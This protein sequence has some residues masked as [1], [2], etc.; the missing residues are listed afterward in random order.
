MPTWRRL[1]E[2]LDGLDIGFCL[3]DD[4]DRTATW[5]RSFL[6]LFPEHEGRVH[7]GEPYGEN[8]RRFYTKRLSA[9]DLP[10]I[11]RH[12]SDGIAR[13]RAQSRPFVFYHD[14]QWLRVASLPMPEGGR[15]RIWTRIADPSA[16]GT[17]PPRHG[18]HTAPPTHRLEALA[19]AVMVLDASGNVTEAN[20]A[21]LALYGVADP[22]AILGKSYEAVL[23]AAWTMTPAS[24]EERSALDRALARLAED[25]RFAGAP[26][27]VP[28]PGGRWL[29]V[30]EQHGTDGILYS[31]HIDIT[32]MKLQQAVISEARD[33]AHRANLTK[34][35]FLAMMSHE[36]RTPMHGIIGMT[37][38]LL[39]SRLDSGQRAQ[40]EAIQ[41]SAT[42]L[43]TIL[44]DI[45]DVSRLEMGKV[46]LASV[47]FSVA[48]LVAD[49]GRILRP[50]AEARGLRLDVSAAAMLQQPVLG[51][52]ARVRQVLLNL[53][54][55]AVKFT[56]T[57]SITIRADIGGGEMGPQL[58]LEVSDT[59]IGFEES[60]L[61]QLFGAFEQGGPDIARRFGGTGLG[62]SISR[63]LVTMMG[64]RIAATSSPGKGSCF[65]VDLPLVMS[66]SE[67]PPPT[68]AP[69][70]S[71][72]SLPIAG[73]RILVVE[74]NPTNQVLA[75]AIL[76]RQ[77]HEV[78]LARDGAAAIAAAASYRPDLVLMDVQ[79]PDMDGFSAAAILRETVPDGA[80]LPIV[81]VTANAMAGDRERCLA[82]GM[83]DYLPKPFKRSDLIAMV[84]RW[85]GGST[86]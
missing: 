48:E 51:D 39:D 42:A 15:I 78:V 20:R 62:L 12:I 53:A 27:E 85:R 6:R 68:A 9:A 60:R 74:D 1:G 59:G 26:F 86:G 40:A 61:E 83:N 72:I 19:D 71:A 57:G 47:P 38:L 37:E 3:F 33:A 41:R 22:S 75:E 10:D 8:L 77:G 28:L 45:L 64:G 17:L 31:T 52:P 73:A 14:G 69:A 50:A 65:R 66:S 43:L 5:N 82:R 54:S 58:L 80:S 84:D 55:N 25:R 13:H 7:V 56:L 21:F 30:S 36:V 34:T 16:G 24:A 49:V 4:Q 81:A 76:R 2:I 63:Q 44:N 35:T 23:A 70:A 11:E 67:D 46:E 32:A 29:R 79:L 18:A